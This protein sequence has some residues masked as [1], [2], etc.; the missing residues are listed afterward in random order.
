MWTSPYGPDGPRHPNTSV[1]TQSQRLTCPRNPKGQCR[2]YL[3]GRSI[4]ITLK[5]EVS[6]SLQRQKYLHHLKAEVSMSSYAAKYPCHPKDRNVHIA[7]RHQFPCNR[8]DRSLHVTPWVPVST[9][10]TSRTV[11]S[12]LPPTGKTSTSPSGECVHVVHKCVTP[13][14]QRI[15]T[16]HEPM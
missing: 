10:F 6:T 2:C 12:I 9:S 5:A 1:A 13:T 8:K 16:T 15:L 11:Q 14:Y 3:K 7:K 4:Y